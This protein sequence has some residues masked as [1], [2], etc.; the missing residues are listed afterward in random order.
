MTTIMHGCMKTKILQQSDYLSKSP[1][2]VMCLQYTCKTVPLHAC[3]S[4]S[5]RYTYAW[6]KC[7]RAG[8]L[9]DLV[10][11]YIPAIYT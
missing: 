5:V 3:V 1:K 8:I 10:C 6:E 9:Q 11:L 2:L 4:T 7:L